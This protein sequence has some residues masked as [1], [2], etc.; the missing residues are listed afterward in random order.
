MK[1]PL[2]A[3]AAALGIAIAAPQ[4]VAAELLFY[5]S[6][7][8]FLN[9]PVNRAFEANNPGTTIRMFQTG[10]EALI[11]K[12]ELEIQGKGKPDADVIWLHGLH[13]LKRY[14]QKGLLVKYVPPDADKIAPAYRD[15]SGFF[16]AATVAHAVLMYNT[17]AL[18]A[19]TA[20]RSWR[21]LTAPR[22]DNKITFAN[23]RI[24]GTG[25]AVVSALVQNLGWPYI[26]QLAKN[27]PQIAAGHPAMVSTIIAGERTVGPMLD[28][29][30][31]SAQEKKQPIGF[32]FPKEGAVAAAA[33]VAIVNGTKNV[34]EARKFVD[35]YL[36]KE[37]ASILQKA[38]VYHPRT[39]VEP[40]KGWPPIA[41]ITAMPLDW[42]MHAKS[43]E[44]V[45][46]RFSDLTEK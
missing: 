34:A 35:F 33:Y 11:D 44:D 18:N 12:L 31:V 26:E 27:R 32:V 13:V 40:P 23:P 3:L 30:I 19:S 7:P 24:S 39:D 38:G 9:D 15:S 36:S 5:S 2:T 20:P 29:S 21:D 16:H 17:N 45:K 41:E 1:L 10:A 14:A 8:R 25:A 42:E 28:Y 43:L 46:K 6:V 37:T 22:F 4:A